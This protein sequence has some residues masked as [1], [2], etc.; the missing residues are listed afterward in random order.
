MQSLNEELTTVNS[1]LHA[2]IE[3]HQAAHND[4]AS[5]LT[6]T[7]IAVLFLD[8]KLRIRRFTPEVGE[9][10]EMLASDVGRPLTDLAKKFVDP[11]LNRD[12]ER[13]LVTLV[14][15]ER[16]VVGERDRWYL[17]R[18]TPYRTA[19]N[20]I[21][22][23][24]V[25]FVDITARVQAEAGLRASEEKLRVQNDHTQEILDSITDAFYSVDADFNFHLREPQ[26]RAAAWPP[27]RGSGRQELLGGVSPAGGDRV[28]FEEAGGDAQPQ[29]RA[30]RDAFAARRL[31]ST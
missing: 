8:R 7:N 18:V 28:S 12:A 10:F 2:K 9:L 14:P 13:V 29:A 15:H 20:R 16:E 30:V 26:D 4:L 1:Q 5:L 19:D 21:D 31:D 17:R 22:G 24:V 6:S 3:E 27:P 25:S 23:V 11:D